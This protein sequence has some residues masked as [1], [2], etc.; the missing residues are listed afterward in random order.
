[1]ATTFTESDLVFGENSLSTIAEADYE[2]SIQGNST[3][4]AMAE[5]DKVTAMMRAYRQFACFTFKNV[6]EYDEDCLNY[7]S[8]G[9]EWVDE[10]GCNH[11]GEATLSDMTATQI[12]DLP[13][14]FLNSL[15]LAQS[16][17]ASFDGQCDSEQ[18]QRSAGIVM[19][20]QGPQT[21]M[22]R[23]GKPLELPFCKDAMRCLSKYI[24]WGVE[25][26]R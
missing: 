10:D 16:L 13:A 24:E 1:M 2:M 9:F 14:S 23:A 11:Y 12:A 20:T 5:T 17:Q 6:K 8:T 4:D 3:W 15:K 19:I 22:F 26:R 21:T 25:I 7:N 18:E